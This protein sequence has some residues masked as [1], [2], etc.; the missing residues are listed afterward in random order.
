MS[1]S[2]SVIH[3]VEER[4]AHY[5]MP[6]AAIGVLTADGPVVQVFGVTSVDNPLPVT[7]DTLFQVGSNTKTMT[8]TL[9]MLL[10]EQ[11]KLDLD[12]PIRD[13]IRDFA[14][15]DEQVAA[16]ST[17]RQLLTHSTGW[18]GDHFIDTGHGSDAK[19]RYMESMTELPQLAPPDT[20]FSY[21]NSAF[22]V[23]GL[24]IETVT[25]MLWEEAMIEMLFKPL[26]MWDSLVEAGD[27]MLKRFAV[28]HDIR[29]NQDPRVAAPWPLP[30]AM[31]AAG[32]VAASAQ[33]MLTYAQFYFD[34]GHTIS[35]DQLLSK[36]AM[37]QLWQ[38]QFPVGSNDSWVAHSW[39]VENDG[40]FK[41]YRHG[42]ATVGQMSAFKLIPEKQ[43][44]YVSLTNGS[45]G[46]LF[47][48]DIERF[49]LSEYCGITRQE[50]EQKQPTSAQI[51]EL[52]G[53]YSRPMIDLEI[54]L[55]SD[56]LMAQITPKQG[57]PT[58]ETPPQP[59]SPWFNIGLL[60]NGDFV[61][62]DGPSRGTQG[63][64]VRHAD[65]SLGWVRFSSRLH[66]KQ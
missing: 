33:D 51:D 17:V 43:F 23:A 15:R 4:M 12:A 2:Q 25:G 19:R 30:R 46:K 64:L 18:I 55:D 57:F 29:P 65:G 13:I 42:G 1:L 40:G 34:N 41:S 21:N 39:F 8:A 36:Q 6:G 49:L 7:S 38:P 5:R 47:N 59:Q 56:Q 3:F 60:A 32:A 26:G 61:A 52:V 35:G 54:K 27:V 53:L 62:L 20:A 11:G 31:Y 63:Q 24:V 48:D 10:S 28:G 58:L 22:A 44:A 14:V 37:T 66:V 9:L 16:N 50:P 45:N